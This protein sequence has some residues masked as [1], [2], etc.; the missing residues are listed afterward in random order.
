M[1]KIKVQQIKGYE[2]DLGVFYK[3]PALNRKCFFDAGDFDFKVESSIQTLYFDKDGS[4]IFCT[5]TITPKIYMFGSVGANVLKKSSFDADFK[6][7]YPEVTCFDSRIVTIQILLALIICDS[8]IDS[9]L[10]SYEDLTKLLYPI[11]T[12]EEA[13]H[14]LRVNG[15]L[16]EEPIYGAIPSERRR[17]WDKLLGVPDKIVDFINSLKPQN[18]N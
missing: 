16:R 1:K 7:P 3:G 8:D 11:P 14:F 12:M 5:G 4:E 17:R 2:T 13:K 10:Y 6:T 18:G 15:I 9:D